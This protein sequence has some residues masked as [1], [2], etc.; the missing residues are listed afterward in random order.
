M[1][2]AGQFGKVYLATSREDKN[3]KFAIK[4]IHTQKLEDKLVNQMHQELKI[5]YKL[6]HPFICNYIES[7]E[8]RKYIY[9][10]ME[11]CQGKDL[12]KRIEEIGHY[13]EKTAANIIHKILEGLNHIHSQNVVHR[14]LKPEN[15]IIDDNG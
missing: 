13:D 5:L 1:L 3:I 8:D 15:I 6:D 10:I 7:F 11:Y 4:I 9:I 14:D 12:N 2:G